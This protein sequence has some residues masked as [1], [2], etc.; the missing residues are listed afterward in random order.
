MRRT[1]RGVLGLAALACAAWTGG[2]RPAPRSFRFE[3][4]E[5]HV[6]L[7]NGLRVVLVPD[8]TTELV[9]VAVRYE[10]GARDDPQGKA[11]LAHLVEHL[12]FQLRPGGQ[13]SAPLM[14]FVRHATSSFNAYTNWDSTHYTSES[15]AAMLDW[16][17]KVEAVRMAH[18]CRSIPPGEFLRERE[19]V[20]NEIRQRAAEDVASLLPA[21]LAA[22]YPP[23][24]P[25]ARPVGGSDAE[26]AGISLEDACAFMD[27]HYVP[28][29]A[30]LIVAGNIDVAA[31]EAAATRWFGRV[32]AGP[33]V[34]RAFVPPAVPGAERLVRDASLRRPVLVVAW[35][36][37]SLSTSR[38][39]AARI[40]LA[41]VA[42]RAAGMAAQAGDET[43]VHPALLGGR[44]AP[45]FAM[46]VE[47]ADA[48]RL[49]DALALVERAVR[50]TRRGFHAWRSRGRRASQEDIEEL[51]VQLK[52]SYVEAVE[53]L[54]ARADMIADLVQFESDIPFLSDKAYL[55]HGLAELDAL[56]SS[57]LA[58]AVERILT[59]DAA[60]VIQFRATGST[61]A[62]RRSPFRFQTRSHDP[63]EE[64]AASPREA[65]RPLETPP[66]LKTL[67]G[68]QR[69]RLANGLRVVLLPVRA[70]P[71][72]AVRL[73]VGAG[74]AQSSGVPGIA[75]VA[76]DL[77]RPPERGNP[78]RGSSIRVECTA[79]PDHT[80]CATGGINMYLDVMLE[81]VAAYA[82][83]GRYL[84][85]EVRRRVDQ[86]ARPD[87]D[88][89]A[90]EALEAHYTSALFGPDHPYARG[91]V[92]STK[93]LTADA[94]VDFHRRHYAAGNAALIVAGDFDVAAANRMVRDVFG[95]WRGGQRAAPA[96]RESRPPPGP[97]HIGVVGEAGA[98]TQILL[99]YRAPA[100]IDGQEAAR[101]ILAEMLS[102]RVERVRSRLGAA[103]TASAGR[104][105][106]LGPTAYTAG[107]EV[108]SERAGEA[109]AAMRE[110]IAS[111]HRGGGG[112]ALDFARARRTV[113]G[114][115]L[116]EST[117]ARE[118]AARLATVA[119]FDLPA[120][121]HDRLVRRAATVSLAEIRALL[122][123]ELVPAHEVIVLLAPR[124]VLERAFA[125]AGVAAATYVDPSPAR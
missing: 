41:G 26:V 77:L 67:A 47:V 122:R 83:R 88:R 6:Q 96:P 107:A 36:I 13:S 43:R 123:A 106:R 63:R 93:G 46:F 115:L 105:P 74:D 1:T 4:S 81:G 54:Q 76:A 61:G 87:P 24:H 45:V 18:D 86:D 125:E 29:R 75:R 49:D 82:A 97:Q 55:A 114:D 51:K 31:V 119:A 101:R 11:G 109:L 44:H 28:Q 98:Q 110:A 60:T 32:P 92:A 10:V 57:E 121:F 68:A 19:V 37:P 35:P 38:G 59:L 56:A 34:R 120:D 33:T 15:R 48:G 112:V 104:A 108:D 22:V 99:G 69:L 23:G 40:Q 117:V 64:L 111:L 100:G 79:D 3:Y 62:A 84:P 58:D 2:C 124:P 70:M 73:V 8:R 91:A 39:G 5:Q 30:T 9:Q 21:V 27:A 80:T 90:R 52:T 12:L 85:A 103:Y 20:R 50:Q 42:A 66:R 53:T 102:L 14:E 89:L 16:L 113:V 94:L 95:D 71:I 78:L 72:V 116:T 17:L 25:Y 118:L 65:E 7:P